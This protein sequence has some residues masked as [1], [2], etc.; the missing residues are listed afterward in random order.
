MMEDM[1]GLKLNV[2]FELGK[3]DGL[4]VLVGFKLGEFDGL[5]VTGTIDGG[6][7]TVEV[8]AIQAL[9]PASRVGL[10]ET[11]KVPS[12]LKNAIGV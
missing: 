4:G 1:I 9:S 3:F 8:D 11:Y 7:V 12:S 2:G 5:G 6:V 10:V